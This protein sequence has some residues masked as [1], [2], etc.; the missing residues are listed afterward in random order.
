MGGEQLLQ[1]RHVPVSQAIDHPVAP[2]E[3]LR[4][5]QVVANLTTVRR[6]GDCENVPSPLI[7]IMPVK[8][9]MGKE[10]H[11]GLGAIALYQKIQENHGI[12]IIFKAR[13]ASKTFAKQTW[14][15]L[16]C[17]DVP[18]SLHI[19]IGETI[20]AWLGMWSGKYKSNTDE[21]YKNRSKDGLHLVVASQIF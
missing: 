7:G 2:R 1:E 21:I 18:C 3:A 9:D 19:S 20:Y 11:E 16:G 10:R 4:R 12:V 6:S 17:D 14:V 5:Q 15:V 8:S 13:T